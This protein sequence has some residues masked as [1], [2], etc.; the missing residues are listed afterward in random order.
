MRVLSLV[1]LILVLA[2]PTRA[3]AIDTKSA[4]KQLYPTKGL[5]TRLADA[6]TD[7]ERATIVALIPLMEQQLRSPVKYY[8]SIAYSPDQGLVS[9]ALQGAFN[10][11]TTEAADAASIAACNKVRAK[12]TKPCQLAA[13]ILPKKYKP[14]DLTLSYDATEA[15]NRSFRREKAPKSFAISATSGAWGVGKTDATAIASCEKDAAGAGDCRVVIH[16]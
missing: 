3:E 4:R 8:S 9:D 14:R 11:H 7:S 13:R 2:A 5:S 10:F 16:D 15:F 1:V 12:G 6:L